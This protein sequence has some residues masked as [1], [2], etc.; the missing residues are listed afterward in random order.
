MLKKL[1]MYVLRSK[2]RLLDDGGDSVL[3]GLAGPQAGAA[4][5]AAGLAFPARPHHGLRH[6]QRGASRWRPLR[7]VGADLQAA[8][9]WDKFV[10]A[11]ALPP[12]HQAW[13]WLDIREACPPSP[14]PF[15]RSS[16]PR[17][18]TST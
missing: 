10:A 7:G 9:L 2:V 5:E 3:I 8:A 1:S 15:R 13:Q 6:R 12:A 16:S 4:L 17:C 18:S 11:G 14:C